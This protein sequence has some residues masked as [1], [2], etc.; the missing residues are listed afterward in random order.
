MIKADFVRDGG[1]TTTDLYVQC[2]ADRGATWHDIANFHFTTSSLVRYVN[3]SGAT[4]V[5]TPAALTDGAI[6]ANTST[7]ATLTQLFRVKY[8][9]TG[10]Y[11]G[12]STAK[13]WM[14]TR[15]LA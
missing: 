12:V 13:V 8:T 7:D 9:T 15:D 5:T 10:T 4:A 2:S 3:L 11:T 6:T 1:G 14:V